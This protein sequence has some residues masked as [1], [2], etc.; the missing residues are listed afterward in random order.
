MKTAKKKKK[1][2]SNGNELNI[3]ERNIHLLYIRTN[4][5]VYSY[6]AMYAS[7]KKKGKGN[8]KNKK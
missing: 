4:T 8:I 3:T 1:W 6:V 7:V 5:C 2:T